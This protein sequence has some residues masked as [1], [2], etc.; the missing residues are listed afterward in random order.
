MCVTSTT[1]KGIGSLYFYIQKINVKTD[2]RPQIINYNGENLG[3]M[4]HTISIRDT[5]ENQ[6]QCS[7]KWKLNNWD[8]I[9]LKCFH[10]VDKKTESKQRQPIVWENM[11]AHQTSDKVFI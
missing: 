1:K 2:L 3:V 11:F 5:L 7:G 6:P 4:S 9:K 10:T 8:D